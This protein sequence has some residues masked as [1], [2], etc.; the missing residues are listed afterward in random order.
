MTFF[1]IK[2]FHFAYRFIAFGYKLL[3]EFPLLYDA[4][5]QL[6][7]QIFEMQFAYIEFQIRKKKKNFFNHLE[8]K[9]L[10][11]SIFMIFE[12]GTFYSE[13]KI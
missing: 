9:R 12:M 10:G 8:K 7:K 11:F 1:S 5:F 13:K 2:N 6:S 3:Y 4:L